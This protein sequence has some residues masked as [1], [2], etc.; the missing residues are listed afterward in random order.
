MQDRQKE[1]QNVMYIYDRICSKDSKSRQILR[2]YGTCASHDVHAGT[3]KKA[4]GAERPF[5]KA[6]AESQRA[7]AEAYLRANPERKRTYASQ[8]AE[9]TVG[10]T[11]DAGNEYIY[12]P[13]RV[14]GGEAVKQMP[15]RLFLEQIVSMFESIEAKGKR[16]EDDAKEQAIARKRSTENRHALFTALILLVVSALFVAF[17]YSVFFVISDVDVSGSEIYSESEV[18]AAAGFEIGDNL[19]S[20]QAGQAAEG[21]TFLCPYIKSVQISRTVPNSVAIVVEDDTAVY[22]ANIYGDIVEMSAGLRVLSVTDEGGARAA[23][24]TKLVLPAIKY[25]VAGRTITFTDERDERYIKSVLSSV[26]KSSLGMEGRITKID[27]SDKYGITINCDGKYI[28]RVGT[29]TDCDLK[30]RMAYKTIGNTAFDREV[31]ATID[32][33]EVGEASVRYDIRLVVD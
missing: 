13:G 11:D 12:R 32:I 4:G 8:S 27:L 15:L 16:D 30:L 33:S 29:E 26:S 23:G 24:L 25:S 28:L 10:Y 5:G 9:K 18:I 1:P 2:E 20:F 7:R 31:P 21:I 14:Y 6:F 17:V 3:Q 19:Y 22:Y